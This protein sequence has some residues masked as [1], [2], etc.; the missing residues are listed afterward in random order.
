M[1]VY[2]YIY[3]RSLFGYGLLFRA[4]SSPQNM[5][6]RRCCGKRRRQRPAY[7]PTRAFYNF[8]LQN[9]RNKL[10]DSFRL[11]KEAK[12]LARKQGTTIGMGQLWARFVKHKLV[13]FYHHEY[14]ELLKILKRTRRIE[15]QTTPVESRETQAE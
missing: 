5:C 8:A 1:H 15:H 12:T 14:T 2:I 6:E 9:L 13:Q 11:C 3:I 7:W 4:I 10:N